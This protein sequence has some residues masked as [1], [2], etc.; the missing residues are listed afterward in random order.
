MCVYNY[1]TII[2]VRGIKK[3]WFRYFVHVMP[4]GPPSCEQS[5]RMPMLG[6]IDQAPTPAQVAP[7]K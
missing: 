4:R 2:V 1:F 5:L 6:G 7:E 3:I